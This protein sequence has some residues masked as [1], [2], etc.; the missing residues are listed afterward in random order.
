[1]NEPPLLPWL[2]FGH[3]LQGKENKYGRELCNVKDA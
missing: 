3:E 1:M 2:P